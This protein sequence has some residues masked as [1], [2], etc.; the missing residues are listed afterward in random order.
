MSN[1]VISAIESGRGAFHLDIR[2]HGIV[3]SADE[4]IADG[5]LGL[6][7][8]PT[9]L[10]CAALAACTTMTLRIYCN[11]RQWALN[12]IRTEVTQVPRTDEG[13]Q[14]HFDRT[15]HLDSDLSEDKAAT[16]LTVANRCPV[17][18]TLEARS[19]IGTQLKTA[20]GPGAR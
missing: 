9:E 10:L 18:L 1:E 7:L 14:A 2:A 6:G 13:R 17:H 16:L 8:T 12:T 4:P 15:I 3:I 11:R 20:A 5:G 19:K